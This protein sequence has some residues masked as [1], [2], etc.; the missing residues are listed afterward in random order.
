VGINMGYYKQQQIIEESEFVPQRKR[1]NA[2][3][4]R[5]GK[6]YERRVAAAIGGKRNLDKSRPHTD[7]ETDE[8][9]YEIKSTISPAPKWLLSAMNQCVLAAKESNKEMGGVIKV[10]TGGQGGISRAF[11]ITEVDLH[12]NRKDGADP[13]GDEDNA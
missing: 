2:N 11:L 10:Y 3:N 8:T 9:V 6:E 1:T 12:A 13:M 4:R 7:V 5:R